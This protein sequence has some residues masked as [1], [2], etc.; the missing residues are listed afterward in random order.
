M[1]A[2]SVMDPDP[3]G[4]ASNKNTDSDPYPDQHQ[5]HKL[6]PELDP[7]YNLQMTSQNVWNMS[8]FILAL[9]QG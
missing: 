6:D 8:L 4:S 2:N 1:P 5:S 7:H 9:F 3:H